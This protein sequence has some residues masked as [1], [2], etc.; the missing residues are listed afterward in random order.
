MLDIFWIFETRSA[1]PVTGS[2][3]IGNF[4]DVVCIDIEATIGMVYAPTG[5]C[6]ETFTLNKGG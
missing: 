2:L 4:D 5:D 6:G 3:N 1:I